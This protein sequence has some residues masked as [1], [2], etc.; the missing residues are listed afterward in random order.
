[1]VRSD[2]DDGIGLLTNISRNCI[3]IHDQ[4][5][6]AVAAYKLDKV[7]ISGRDLLQKRNL[8]MMLQK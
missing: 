6:G 1:M 3:A 4:S 2:D 5:Q 7:G 8:T